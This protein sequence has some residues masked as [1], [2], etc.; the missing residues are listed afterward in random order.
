MTDTLDDLLKLWAPE[1]AGRYKW[2]EWQMWL[3]DTS[4]PSY[5]KIAET[6]IAGT[7]AT[8][9]AIHDATTGA[10]LVVVPVE[11]TDIMI[12][13]AEEMEAKALDNIGNQQTYAGDYWQAMLNASTFKETDG[14]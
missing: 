2:A 7:M 5:R 13:E 11:P 8:A 10:G 4:H 9:R 12:C 1:I 3:N 6:N 14:G